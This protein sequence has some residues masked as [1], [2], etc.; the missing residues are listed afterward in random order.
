M[1]YKNSFS[2]WKLFLG[3]TCPEVQ[4]NDGAFWRMT[5]HL[6]CRLAE[7]FWLGWWLTPFFLAEMLI[8]SLVK[9]T[10]IVFCVSFENEKLTRFPSYLNEVAATEKTLLC[11][12]STRLRAD[13]ANQ[14]ACWR[15]QVFKVEETRRSTW[16]PQAFRDCLWSQ[17]RSLSRAL[18][19]REESI[20]VW[21]N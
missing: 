17:C 10:R 5:E 18:S 9:S 20:P 16:L 1:T 8:H 3:L 15:A 12:L 14:F 13:S 2:G 6:L 19:A 4:E 11:V 7:L 21:K